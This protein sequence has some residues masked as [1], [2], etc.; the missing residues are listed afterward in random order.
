MDTANLI[1]NSYLN[2]AKGLGLGDLTKVKTGPDR[3]KLITDIANAYCTATDNS[4][5]DARDM[6]LSGLMLLFWG[7]VNKMQEKCKAVKGYEFEDF[8]MVLFN[9]IETACKYRAWQDGSV[10]AEQCI[11]SV[12]ASR[13]AA[14]ILQMITVL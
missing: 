5:E 13:G 6:N 9:C 3:A 7:E 8:V 14:A 2:S 12:I 4:D 1:K 10:N 11:R